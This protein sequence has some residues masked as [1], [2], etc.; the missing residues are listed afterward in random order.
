MCCEA[1]VFQGSSPLSKCV[2]VCVDVSPLHGL[3]TRFTDFT[4]PF[5]DTT[6]RRPSTVLALPCASLF[7]V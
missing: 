5:N 4:E 7:V 6:T 1:I 2:C 3:T